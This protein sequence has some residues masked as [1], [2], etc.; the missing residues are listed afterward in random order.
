MKLRHT[1]GKTESLLIAGHC[2]LAVVTVDSGETLQ[3]NNLHI[4]DTI[5]VSQACVFV[6]LKAMS[7]FQ[8]ALHV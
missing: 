1:H 5:M 6:A 4:I 3:A 8:H 2:D 7:R